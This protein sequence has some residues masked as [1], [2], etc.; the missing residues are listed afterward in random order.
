MKINIIM[1]NTTT[2]AM[3][4][5]IPIIMGIGEDP[6]S[7]SSGAI[8]NRLITHDKQYSNT[9]VMDFHKHQNNH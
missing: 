3:A 6:D 8:V 9:N 1:T 2:I 7:P 4:T 5:K